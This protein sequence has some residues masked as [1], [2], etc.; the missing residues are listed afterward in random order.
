M[1]K[2]YIRL[3]VNRREKDKKEK[4]II[5]EKS[6]EMGKKIEKKKSRVE[7]KGRKKKDVIPV[8]RR[9]GNE[10]E[11]KEG[12]FV[13]EKRRKEVKR[14]AMKDGEKKWSR[15]KRESGKKGISDFY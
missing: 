5:T 3:L 7:K 4:K 1:G 8:N 11:N 14:E 2:R 13:G 10:R 15:L 9:E 12:W 6:D